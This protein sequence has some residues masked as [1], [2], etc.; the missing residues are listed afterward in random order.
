[1]FRPDIEIEDTM[2]VVVTYENHATLSYS[3]N[4]FNA[5]EGY[6]IVFNGTRGRSSTASSSRFT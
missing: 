4:A 2:N 1:V 6:V 3:L 5:W